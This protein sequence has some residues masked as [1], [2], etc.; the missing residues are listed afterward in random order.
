MLAELHQLCDALKLR[1]A[2]E[3]IE[4]VLRQAQRSKPSYSQFL[5]DLLSRELQDK[6][7][8]TIANRLKQCGLTDYWTLESFPWH[9]QKSLARQRKAIEELAELDFLERAESVVFVGKAGVGKSGLASAILL[10][11]LYAGRTARAITAQNLFEEFEHSQADRSTKRLIKRLSSVDLLLVDE[12]GYVQARTTPQINQLFR[13]M[14]NRASRKSTIVTTNLLCGAP[15]NKFNAESIFMRSPLL[16]T[17][18]VGHVTVFALRIKKPV[19][20][21]A[22]SVSVALKRPD[23]SFGA[24]TDSRASSFT[25][26]SARV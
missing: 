15:H 19:R 7:R 20:S 9:I 16:Q 26:G 13:L 2:R 14:D 6:R 17:P 11:A 5:Q 25:E 4:D 23:R 1:Y 12:F 18:R 22:I 24:T 21:E 10:K 3:A 8:R